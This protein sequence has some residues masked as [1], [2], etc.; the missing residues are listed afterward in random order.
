MRNTVPVKDLLLFLGSNAVI[1]VHEVKEG[2][3]WFFQ[4]RIG[5]S[6]EV[7]EVWENAFLKLLWVLDWATKCLEAECEASHDIGTGDV[8][9]VAP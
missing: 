6:L 4:G 5:A 1:F 2:A 9:Q 3:L 7:S 8:K